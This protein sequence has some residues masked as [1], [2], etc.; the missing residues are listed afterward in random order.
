[1]RGLVLEM[2]LLFFF[3]TA[4]TRRPCTVVSRPTVSSIYSCSATRSAVECKRKKEGGM[5]VER[6]RGE[7]VVKLKIKMKIIQAQAESLIA[8][9]N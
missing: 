6:E 3:D 9:E 5:K 4:A 8:L 2:F 1:M 7:T